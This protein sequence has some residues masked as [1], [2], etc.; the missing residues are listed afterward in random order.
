MLTRDTIVKTMNIVPETMKSI[1]YGETD[2]ETHQS[3][4]IKLFTAYGIHLITAAPPPVAALIA[5]LG[6]K[7]ICGSAYYAGS[8][9]FKLVP[10]LICPKKSEPDTEIET[11]T[12]TLK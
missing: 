4:L 2:D 3:M 7:R 8:S 11:A 10:P 9:L 1:W 12:P 6:L 5:V